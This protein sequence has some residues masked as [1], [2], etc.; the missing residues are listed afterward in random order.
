MSVKLFG[1]PHCLQSLKA[2]HFNF[3][4]RETAVPQTKNK[5]KTLVLRTSTEIKGLLRQ[6][7]RPK[8]H[9]LA[10]MVEGP[11]FEYVSRGNRTSSSRNIQVADL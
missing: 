2:V 11:L 9:S 6:M 10:S 4:M 3:S 7:A 5:N 1:L 8:H